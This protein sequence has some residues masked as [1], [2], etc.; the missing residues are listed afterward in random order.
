HAHAH[1]HTHTYIHAHSLKLRCWCVF[2][3]EFLHQ[4]QVLF[5]KTILVHLCVC[6]C[7]CVCVYLSVCTPSP[8]LSWQGSVTCMP[9][10]EHWAWLRGTNVT[11][12]LWFSNK[13][14]SLSRSSP[15]RTTE[16]GGGGA[17]GGGG[18]GEREKRHLH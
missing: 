7:V 2:M 1:A 16:G 6:V 12:P 9:L 11:V 3:V 17:G 10:T 8:W 15:C 13:Q 18:G 14:C 5:Y 4:Q